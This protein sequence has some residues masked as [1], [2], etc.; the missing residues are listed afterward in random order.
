[1][2]KSLG[3]LQFEGVLIYIH[4][5]ISTSIIQAAETMY[6]VTEQE[7]MALELIEK[8]D[9]WEVF[10]TKKS[11]PDYLLYLEISLYPA[12]YQVHQKTLNFQQHILHQP[13]ES[14]LYRIFK[15]QKE[16]KTKGDWVSSVT[17]LVNKYELKLNMKHT[18]KTIDYK[19]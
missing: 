4:T 9:L 12:R 11:C 6:N 10:G 14:L 17:E 15:V 19:Y 3:K 7:L 8:S 5:L 2:I 16:N 13:N 1:M 18:E